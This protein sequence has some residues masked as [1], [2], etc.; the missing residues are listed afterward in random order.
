MASQ[1]V[2]A[3]PT[4]AQSLAMKAK[5]VR[6][7]AERVTVEFKET[8]LYDALKSLSEQPQTRG[9]NLVLSPDLEAMGIRN[10]K[11][12]LQAQNISISSVLRLILG[13]DLRYRPDAGYVLILP[14]E[15]YRKELSVSE[16][17]VDG[18]V[19]TPP[20]APGASWQLLRDIIERAVTSM[21]NLSVAAWADQGG[22]ATIDWVPSGRLRIAQ[23]AHGHERVADLLAQLRRVVN[24]QPASAAATTDPRR[25]LRQRLGAK[26]DLSLDNVPL[27]DAIARINEALGR[28]NL[29]VDP[30]DKEAAGLLQ[31]QVTRK[32]TQVPGDKALEQ[33]LPEGLTYKV[34]PD[35]IV[36]TATALQKA[37]GALVTV[38]YPVTRLL[39]TPKP[40]DQGAVEAKQNALLYTTILS[41]TTNHP[42]VIA[43]SDSGGPACI[44]IFRNALVVTQNPQGQELVAALLQ[45]MSTQAPVTR[46]PG[47]VRPR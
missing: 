20:D 23:T 46:T 14:L 38:V 43:W 17:A 11:V 8:P 19:G 31:R 35:C 34:E 4:E 25:A 32:L 3:P 39:A 5:T 16:Y 40:G 29:I 2:A 22:P 15:Q 10:R 36:V 28:L 41:S 27:G 12:T 37:A 9:L 45:R 26:I 1:V 30:R 6:L 7:L 47:A 21:G 33:I 24:N 18:I 44:E 13:N 42:A